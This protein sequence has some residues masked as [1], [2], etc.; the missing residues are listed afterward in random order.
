[1]FVDGDPIADVAVLLSPKTVYV[2]GA[3][4]V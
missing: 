4:V 2:R 3:P 1:V